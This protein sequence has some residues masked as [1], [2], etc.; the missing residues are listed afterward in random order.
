M[1][2]KTA[3][4]DMPTPISFNDGKP[5]K[6]VKTELLNMTGKDEPLLQRR[7]TKF[8]GG[9][10]PARPDVKPFPQSALTFDDQSIENIAKL[11]FKGMQAC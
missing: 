2:R 7:S 5:V 11:V 4:K 9:S 8:F 10:E 6:R 3:F 1:E